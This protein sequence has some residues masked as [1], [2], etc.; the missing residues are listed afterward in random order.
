MLD[1]I[2]VDM[3]IMSSDGYKRY[4]FQLVSVKHKRLLV[5]FHIVYIR[6]YVS[7]RTLWRSKYAI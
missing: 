5:S 7:A 2:A 4:S 3:T 6:L 1:E